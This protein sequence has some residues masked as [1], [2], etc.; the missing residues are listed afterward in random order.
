MMS[1]KLLNE[2]ELYVILSVILSGTSRFTSL[3]TIPIFYPLVFGNREEI[4][5]PR[6]KHNLHDALIMRKDGFVT[7]PKIHAPDL[8]ILVR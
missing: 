4:M 1:I 3:V 5:G 8:D 2:L 7:V 6:F